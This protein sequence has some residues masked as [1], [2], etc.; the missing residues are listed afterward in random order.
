MPITPLVVAAALMLNGIAGIAFGF[1]YRRHG[2][3]AAMIAHF[4]ADFVIYVVGTT[5]LR[6]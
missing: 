2:L 5:F 4:I 1:L 3:E 6:H